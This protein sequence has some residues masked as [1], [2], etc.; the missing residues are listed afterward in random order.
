LK[1]SKFTWLAATVILCA[2]A[3]AAC[4]GA[5]NSNNANSNANSNTAANKNTAT[6]PTTNTSAGGDYSTPTAAFKSFYEA[7]KSNNVEGMKRAMSKKTL[8]A[9]QKEADKDKKSI[10][11]AFKEMNKDAPS[12]V[13]EIRDEK[14]DGDKATIEIKDDK[15][16]DWTKVPFVKE[17]GQWRIAIY[18]EMAAAME[19]MESLNPDKK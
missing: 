5:G 12:S 19:K 13:P 10:D 1:T 8:D 2:F 9:I 4:S 3:M 11:E 14:I 16:K 18:D 7:A 6:A 15:M 17:D